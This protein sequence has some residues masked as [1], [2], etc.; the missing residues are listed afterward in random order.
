MLLHILNRGG[1]QEAQ[2]QYNIIGTHVYCLACVNIIQDRAYT[3]V[4]SNN[5]KQKLVYA[6]EGKQTKRW[7]LHRK[8]IRIKLPVCVQSSEKYTTNPLGN[9]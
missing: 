4:T 8:M 6:I 1:A 9:M 2:Q 3:N 7:Q 5:I